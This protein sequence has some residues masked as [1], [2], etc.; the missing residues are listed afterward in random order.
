MIHTCTLKV[1]GYHLDLYG[2]VN[3][4]R[5]LEILEEARWCM[6]EE[7]YDLIELQQK[8]VGFAVVNI[9]INYRMAAY[10]SDILEI[11]TNVARIGGSSATFHQEIIRKNNGD[12]VA[13]A[14][15]TFVT[16]DLNT[17]KPVGIDAEMRAALGVPPAQTEV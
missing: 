2:H 11:R 9:N 16:I 6:L 7:K 1:R 14:D 10:L 5:Y 4:A 12:R 3:N 8:K 17:G 13:D 15:V